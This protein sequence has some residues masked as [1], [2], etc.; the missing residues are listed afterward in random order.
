VIH[1]ITEFYK[2]SKEGS[3]KPPEIYL[4]AN[5]SKMQLPDGREVW[6]T[7]PSAYVKN[8][9]LV[10]ERLLSE[11]GEGYVLKS[12]V[13]NPFPTGHKP[14][15]DVTAEFESELAS[16][17]MQLI[18]ILRWA[19]EIGRIDIYLK[20]SVSTITIPPSESSSRS[21]LRRSIISSSI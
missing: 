18:G 8:S 4:G 1:E 13:K 15:I 20:G 10:V 3:I 11:D 6:T 16:R 21:I 17:F 14:E 12:K 2:A 7:S 9:L 5:I 19:F